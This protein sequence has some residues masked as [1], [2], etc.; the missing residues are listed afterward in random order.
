VAG[1]LCIC[2]GAGSAYSHGIKRQGH[3][4]PAASFSRAFIISAGKHQFEALLQRF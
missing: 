1:A 3:N 4:G 2:G